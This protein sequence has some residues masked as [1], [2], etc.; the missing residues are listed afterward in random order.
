MHATTQG[1]AI[2]IMKLVYLSRV[3]KS[4]L[5]DIDLLTCYFLVCDVLRQTAAYSI[6]NSLRQSMKKEVKAVHC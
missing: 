5:F 2:L 6:L 3:P 1:N 4:L